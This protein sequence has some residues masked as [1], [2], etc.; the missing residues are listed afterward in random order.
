VIQVNSIVYHKKIRSYPRES[1]GL[2][3]FR[4]PVPCVCVCVFLTASQI[5]LYTLK[6]KAKTL[7][8][9]IVYIPLFTMDYNSKMINLSLKK[10]L[11]LLSF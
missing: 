3:S 4:H 9:I 8:I 11:I 2:G 1:Y 10:Y 6:R 5:N 7:G